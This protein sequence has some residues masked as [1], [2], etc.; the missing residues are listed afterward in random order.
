LKQIA[1]K[2]EGDYKY[3]FRSNGTPYY[4]IEEELIP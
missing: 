2:K 3:M 4:W 1:D